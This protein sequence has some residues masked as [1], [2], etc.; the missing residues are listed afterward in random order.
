LAWE[1]ML[2]SKQGTFF[3][4][5]PIPLLRFVRYGIQAPPAHL[6]IAMMVP[7]GEQISMLNYHERGGFY[8]LPSGGGRVG[9]AGIF[10]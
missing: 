9:A 8:Q 3:V 10:P 2:K 6:Q 4:I 5:I 7:I 1:N